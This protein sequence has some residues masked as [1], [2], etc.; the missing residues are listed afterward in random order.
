MGWFCNNFSGLFFGIVRFSNWRNDRF[1]SWLHFMKYGSIQELRVCNNDRV[2]CSLFN[3]SNGSA[4]PAATISPTTNS[5]L[6]APRRESAK[7][8]PSTTIPPT[9]ISWT[10]WRSGRCTRSKWKRS[11]MWAARRPAR[12]PLSAQENQVNITG[13][14][15]TSWSQEYWLMIVVS[16]AVVR[17]Y[18]RWSERYFFH[19]RRGPLGRSPAWTLQRTDRRFQGKSQTWIP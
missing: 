11:T 19:D 3:K 1:I 12:L 2:L 10:N 7:V 9:R 13:I 6:A 8:W 15:W 18:E 14:E 17:S 4:T 16:S 5:T